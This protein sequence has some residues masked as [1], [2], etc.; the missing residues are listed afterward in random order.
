MDSIYLK[1]LMRF[2]GSNYQVWKFQ[3]CTIFTTTGLLK[4]VDGTET[5]PQPTAN[6]FD[7][8][9]ARSA[10]AM[11]YVSSSMDHKQLETPITCETAAEV[12]WIENMASQLRDIGEELSEVTIMSK[13][14]SAL[15][16][17]FG[18]LVTAWDSVSE[19]KQTQTK[20]I[21][22]LIKEEAR[23]AA[24]DD[25]TSSSAAMTVQQ[26]RNKGNQ[27]GNG[28]FQIERR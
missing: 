21:E 7:A 12:A 16:Q 2:D 4:L 15:P 9:N 25:A 5:K 1:S 24:M 23:L 13:I 26:K 11:C 8:W 6:N 19:P 14:L 3:M 27:H 22:H 18:P 20:L 17:K 28:R 10:R